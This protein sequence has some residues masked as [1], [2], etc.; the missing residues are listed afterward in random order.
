MSQKKVT[1]QKVDKL[2]FENNITLNGKSVSKF[3]DYITAILD[4]LGIKGADRSIVADKLK[5]FNTNQKYEIFNNPNLQTLLSES[6]KAD[7]ELEKLDSELNGI[8]AW[9]TTKDLLGELQ[10][11]III[12][13]IDQAKSTGN[14][15]EL[16]KKLLEAFNKKLKVVNEILADNIKS[17]HSAKVTQQ[18]TKSKYLKYKLK[19]IRQK[20]N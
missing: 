9:K 17:P 6:L 12:K 11:L 19:Y 15:D 7:Q 13:S 16:V 10:G 14:T 18:K 4:S 2:T 1:S 20:K 5:E 8:A 3:T